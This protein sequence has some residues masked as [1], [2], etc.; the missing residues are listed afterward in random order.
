METHM[1]VE[2]MGYFASFLILVSFL[3]SSVIRLRIVNCA[4]AL[5]YV[6]YA[7]IIRSYP[8]ALM[9]LCLVGI[10]IY[11]LRKLTKKDN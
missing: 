8:T 10:N 6:V 1:I 4:G 2:I 3:M 7:L 5:I 9:N 11:Y